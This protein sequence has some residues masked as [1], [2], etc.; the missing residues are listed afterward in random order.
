MTRSA[1]PTEAYASR[2]TKRALAIISTW[3][4]TKNAEFEVIER[5]V[6]ATTNVGA[7]VFVIDDDGYVLSST[8]AQTVPV[9]RRIIREDCDFAISLHFQSPR[10]LDIYSYMT[11]WNPP[12]YFH[13]FGYVPST[14]KLASHSDVLSCHSDIADAHAINLF[15]GFGRPLQ[16]PLQSLFHSL[17][18][19]FLA[20]KID[21]DSKLF[22][23]GINWEK[24]SGTKGRHHYL[25][26]QLDDENLINIYGP[27]EFYGVKPWEGFKN[28][29]DE[30][31]FDG[32]SVLK[33][34]NASGVCLAFSSAAHQQSGIMSNRLFEGLAA[35]AAVIAN[36]HP[37]IDKYFGDCVYVVDDTLPPEEV[38]RQ[39]VAIL[40]GIRSNPAEALDRARRGQQ[41]LA[42]RFSLEVCLTSLFANH[43]QRASTP[44]PMG[45]TVSVV[46]SYPGSDPVLFA[47]LVDNARRQAGVAVHLHVILTEA[48]RSEFSEEIEQ[49][50]R[51]RAG[52]R[53][54]A[55]CE[56][57]L[58]SGGPR[59]TR[60]RV[61]DDVLRKIR[62]DYVCIMEY[63]ET[64][65]SDH[66]A[67]LVSALERMP[68][69][70][71][72]ASGRIREDAVSPSR[73]RRRFETVGFK[74]EGQL[75]EAAYDGDSGRF[76]FRADTLALVPRV[77]LP[78]LDGC[79]V[80]ALGLWAML[81]GPLALSNV[82]S[83]VVRQDVAAD[84]AP[85]VVAED[86]QVE[87][88]R[89]SVRGNELWQRR[90]ADLSP[91]GRASDYRLPRVELNKI[92][93]VKEQGEGLQF[94]KQGF[95]SAEPGFAWIDGLLGEIEFEMTANE[96]ERELILVVGGRSSGE[97]ADCQT[98]I[99]SVN[100]RQLT[101]VALSDEAT[102]V[103]VPLAPVAGP[104]AVKMRVTMRTN[105]AEQ[106]RNAEG[107][108]LDPRYLGMRL[109]S[110]TVLD[111]PTPVIAAGATYEFRKKG[112][113]IDLLRSGFSQPEPDRVWIDGKSGELAFT[114]EDLPANQAL[115]LV[116]AGRKSKAGAVQRCR[117]EVNSAEALSLTSV[118][119][120]PIKLLIPL[121]AA[122][123]KVDV[124]VRVLASHAEPVQNEAGLVVDERCLGLYLVSAQ[125]APYAHQTP[126][127]GALGGGG[128]QPNAIKQRLISLVP[129][130]ARPLAQRLRSW[131]RS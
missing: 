129:P 109:V 8:S 101:T 7:D 112:S 121:P 39:V 75:I 118:P 32:R 63:G 113:G 125:I 4:D 91:N 130:A 26:Q 108:V 15:S 89:D 131:L 40:H 59:V 38:H 48:F 86:Q 105:H 64:W 97:E 30:I 71:V 24:I 124:K 58:M 95:S 85:P 9:G 6:A 62:A 119:E 2:R 104:N 49:I 116:V 100:G 47:E 110:M 17:P 98:C 126:A 50:C 61:V 10:S 111:R 80:R 16:Q 68:S 102:D 3:P 69:A 54:L 117:V 83:F 20:P 51:G 35:G 42:Q 65:F 92:Y 78:L 44:A 88:I 14:E 72:A 52:A 66:L 120:G 123:G 23:I 79:E 96:R 84:K 107:K 81:S 31:P 34:V 67:Q 57:T 1:E 55:S 43:D 11:L 36:P 127:A 29:V 77:L 82:A 22:Y 41:R 53:Q 5:L 70:Y 103:R 37:F 99:V 27:R 18:G 74:G 90:R 87:F 25:L 122:E 115:A 56:I 114:V 28:Y 13:V 21:A 128:R 45:A 46:L 94:L 106:V 93:R 76:L 19:P 33:E 12:E 73:I 60:G